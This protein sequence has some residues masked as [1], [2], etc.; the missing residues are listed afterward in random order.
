MK[1]VLTSWWETTKGEQGERAQTLEF[2]ASGWAPTLPCLRFSW[3][4][5]VQDDKT[6]PGKESTCPLNKFMMQQSCQQLSPKG[7]YLF[8]QFWDFSTSN[9]FILQGGKT[10]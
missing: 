5:L 4:A 3:S 6:A 1:S 10:P 9:G 2:W 7:M 8:Q